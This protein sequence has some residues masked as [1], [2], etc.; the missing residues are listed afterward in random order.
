MHCQNLTEKNISENMLQLKLM[1]S[2]KVLLEE[3]IDLKY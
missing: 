2:G 3:N 1:N